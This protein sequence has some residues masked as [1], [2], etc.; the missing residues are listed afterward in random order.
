[1]REKRGRRENPKTLDPVGDDGGIT[2]KDG[3]GFYACYILTSLSP[4]HKGHT[5]IGFTVNPKRRIRQHNG[6]ITS[7]AYRTKKKRPWEMVLCIYGF[8]SKVS[9]LQYAHHGGLS[10][11]LP[12]HMEVH[13]CPM[14]D[15]PCFTK[16]DDNSQPEDEEED[17]D[18]SSSNQSQPG[19]PTSSYLLDRHCEKPKGPGTVL[20]DRLAN[21]TGFG[22]LDES[23]E[24]EVSI[25]AM[26][27]EP[28]TVFNDS[29]T[30]FTGFGLL[31]KIVEDKV[32]HSTM[33]IDCWRRSN[34]VTSSTEV[35]VID[36]MTPSPTCR[37]GSSMKRPRVS[38]FIDLTRSPNF[39]EL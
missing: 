37:V 6:E 9:A 23:D 3:K 12:P 2:G 26:E 29:L 16:G 31:E 19:N 21:F 39:I 18:D 22:L 34:F 35:E 30:N 28:E 33:E 25:E 14:D 27:K 13:V 15:L 36:L 10:P 1:M 32:S 24:D 20:D 8:P 7:G 11:S 38:E 4:R 17:D 5:Y